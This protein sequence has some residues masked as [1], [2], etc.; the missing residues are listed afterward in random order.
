MSKIIYSN[1]K[2]INILYIA[3]A[4]LILGLNKRFMAIL[5]FIGIDL[6]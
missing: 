3:K 5:Y 6:V 1:N 4:A 2:I